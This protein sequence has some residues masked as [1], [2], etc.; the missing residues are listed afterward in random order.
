MSHSSPGARRAA[1]IE[2]RCASIDAIMARMTDRGRVNTR[3]LM[4]WRRYSRGCGV[5]AKTR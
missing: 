2:A 1:A 4:R 5:P 3:S